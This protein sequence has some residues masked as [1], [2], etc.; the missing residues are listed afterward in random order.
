MLEARKAMA[1]VRKGPYLQPNLRRAFRLSRRLL[2][3]LLLTMAPAAASSGGEAQ[4]TGTHGR[5][6]TVGSP[7]ELRQALRAVSPGT[8]IRILPGEYAAGIFVASLHGRPDAPMTIE[9]ADP[10]NPPVFVGGETG[11]QITEGSHFVL[12]HLRFRGQKANGLNIDDGGT[13]E[14]PTHHIVLEHISIEDVGPRG[15]FDGIKLS[16]VTDFQIRHCRVEGWGGQAIDMVGCHRG[17]IEDCFF[18]GKEGFS[19]ST[20]PQAK[21]GSSDITIRRC[22]FLNAGQRAVQLGGSTGLAYFRPKG[23][24]YE[25]RNILVEDCLFVGGDAAVS[26]VGVDG[27]T[28]RHNTIIRPNLWVM[29]ILQETR[30]PGFVPCRGGVFE[31]NLIVFRSTLREVVNVGPATAPETFRFAENWWYCEDRPQ[32]S[33]ARLPAAE[34]AGVYGQDPRL[35]QTAEDRWE[36]L[37]PAARKYGARL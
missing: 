13:F 2:V 36:V 11:W 6:L 21:G 15:N 28:F 33:R 7:A 35:R 25:A 26:F 31:N 12:R 1:P 3:P 27:A 24:P 8:T 37:N 32:A 23:V 19:Q 10:Q 18:R 30:E 5:V 4:G 17:T 16:G 20:G 34:T 9:G 14:T 22:V 29:R